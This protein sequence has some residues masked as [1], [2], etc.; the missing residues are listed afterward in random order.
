LYRKAASRE[1]G[2]SSFVGERS[3]GRR[4]KTSPSETATV[5]PMNTRNHGPIELWVNE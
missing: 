4:Q 3:S 5:T 1:I 2:D